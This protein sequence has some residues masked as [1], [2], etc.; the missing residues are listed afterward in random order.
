M[1]AKDTSTIPVVGSRKRAQFE[2][3]LAALDIK[4]SADDLLRMEQAVPAEA[5]AGTRYDEQLMKM[6]DSERNESA[7]G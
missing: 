7:A 1:L 3:S 4:L 6:L 2:E 5:V